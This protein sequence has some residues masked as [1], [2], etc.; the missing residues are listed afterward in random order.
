MVIHKHENGD[1]IDADETNADNAV[2]LRGAGINTIRQLQ[3]RDVDFSADGGEF[4]EA[5]VDS[6]GRKNSVAESTCTFDTNKY[7]ANDTN[8][9]YV[10][11]N[12]DSLSGS[13]TYN[14]CQIAMMK[15]NEWTLFCKE[16]ANEE[17]RAQI[18]KSLFFG[19]NGSDALINN[20]T[21]ITAL[22]TNISRDVGKQ[23]Y[24]AYMYTTDHGTNGSYIGTFSNTTDNNSCSSW[25]NLHA[26]RDSSGGTNTA[27][28]YLPDGVELNK[29]VATWS[30]DKT[31]N[32]I[33]TD[34]SDDETDNPVDCELKGGTGSSSDD[35][36]ARVLVLSK[37]DISWT[38]T[39]T[40]ET[41]GLV[42]YKNDNSVPVFESITDSF[43]SII[44]HNIPSGTFKSDISSLFNSAL[45]SDYEE[46]CNIQVKI[47]T[48][49]PNSW[50]TF[51]KITATS[52]INEAQL[53]TGNCDYRK[54]NTG[55]WTV[56]CN[57]STPELERAEL[58]A[59]LFNSRRILN[60]TNITGVSTSVIR[61]VDKQFYKGYVA[62][63]GAGTTTNT[64]TMSYSG[65][66]SNTTDNNDCSFWSNC[67]TNTYNDGGTS[68]LEVPNGTV[69]NSS[70][71]AGAD[72]YEIGTDTSADDLNNPASISAEVQDS[73]GSY[74][75]NGSTTFLVL[76]K[77]S[78]NWTFH[79]FPNGG[80]SSNNY[81]IDYNSDYGIP[82]FT[83]A[84]IP[85]Y[86]SEDSGWIDYNTVGTFTP[87]TSEPTKA[88]VKLIPKT[89]NPTPGYP[90]IKGVYLRNE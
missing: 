67:N 18:Y 27:Y 46:G 26:H 28:W 73:S 2:C 50:G 58:Y 88:I 66:F 86:N 6:N 34:T 31:S 52:V 24:Y 82:L 22:K 15:P 57:S 81:M 41:N 68:R 35:T 30:N 79:D 25:S 48:E 29:V 1:L 55:E 51:V 53:K 90:S 33:G 23:A 11:I 45:I 44:E 75:S 56:F 5:Y 36:T 83:A 60:F 77:G 85:S 59:L 7:K 74:T 69:I 72:S 37:G 32:E 42:D 62:I 9:P 70:T 64:G 89:T 17:K 80:S 47:K 40:A 43:E 65:V 20:F 14:N 19:T 39:G 4:A 16:G 84:T 12:A 76:S 21:N 8:T 54:T 78:I 13:W 61:D 49:A 63:G 38:F 87:F 3:D 71:A 10:V